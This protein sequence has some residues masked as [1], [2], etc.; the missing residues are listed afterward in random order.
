MLYRQAFRMA[1][2][3]IVAGVHFP[4]DLPAGAMLGL[5][6]GEY[7][8]R[9][10]TRL[11]PCSAWAG[12]PAAAAPLD[13]WVFDTTRYAAN[14]ITKAGFITG[15]KSGSSSAQSFPLAPATSYLWS[16]ACNVWKNRQR[17]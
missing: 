15:Y 1:F 8:L 11:D 13:T 9:R 5:A 7:F 12:S 10:C 6:L 4:V 17:A 2:N 14:P 3:R 16:M